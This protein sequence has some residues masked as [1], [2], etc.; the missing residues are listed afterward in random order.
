MITLK[1][2]HCDASLERVDGV[3]LVDAKSGDLGGTYDYCP[4]N[5]VGNED[6]R[7]HSAVRL[8]IV[9]VSAKVAVDVDAWQLAYGTDTD[10]VAV[11]ART[12][13]GQ[14]LQSM[15]TD[16]LMVRDTMVKGA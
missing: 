14:L 15:V 12:S 16:E 4:D 5:P 7:K 6:D 8:M 2:K 1:C 10:D 9:T 11:D 3:G 13:A